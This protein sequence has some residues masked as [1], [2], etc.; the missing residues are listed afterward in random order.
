MRTFVQ[1]AK[2]LLLDLASA[3]VELAQRALQQMK[4]FVDQL[5]QRRGK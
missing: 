5:K 2:E 1:N 3:C 4:L